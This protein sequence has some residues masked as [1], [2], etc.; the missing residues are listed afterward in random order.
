MAHSKTKEGCEYKTMYKN[1]SNNFFDSKHDYKARRKSDLIGYLKSKHEGVKYP[2]YQCYNEFSDRSN[3]VRHFK[4]KHDGVK[5]PCDHCGYKASNKSN[6]IRHLKSQH[7]GVENSTND[8]IKC[9][10]EDEKELKAHQRR[11]EGQPQQKRNYLES[12]ISSCKRKNYQKEHNDRR[13]HQNATFSEEPIIQVIE[14]VNETNFDQAF[15][16]CF[17]LILKATKRTK[18]A[19]SEKKMK[20]LKASVIPAPAISSR[21]WT[22][23]TKE[24]NFTSPVTLDTANLEASISIPEGDIGK[25]DPVF[26]PRLKSTIARKRPRLMSP[27]LEERA[28]EYTY[29]GSVPISAPTKQEPNPVKILLR[30]NDVSSW[31]SIDLSS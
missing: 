22:M 6:L 21:Y 23:N 17:S 13:G 5:Y 12:K 25:N 7:E 30:R 9:H 14:D 8:L 31:T 1:A 24:E 10:L 19:D 26:F 18:E 11:I 27:E 3:L 15:E 20:R 16:N 28:E 2:C 4:S 29:P